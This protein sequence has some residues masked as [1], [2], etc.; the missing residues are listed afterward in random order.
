M[1]PAP[2]GFLEVQ[3]ELVRADPALF[4]QPRLGEAQKDSMPLMWRLP[5]ANSFS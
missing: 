2:L 3:R 4:G 5:L 1:I